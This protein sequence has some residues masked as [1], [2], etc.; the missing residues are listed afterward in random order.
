MF[1]L[2]LSKK[3]LNKEEK[4]TYQKYI[5]LNRVRKILEGGHFLNNFQQDTQYETVPYSEL[6]VTERKVKSD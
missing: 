3:R 1:V 2:K 4:N 6:K 5:I